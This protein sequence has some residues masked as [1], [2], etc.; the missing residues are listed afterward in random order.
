MKHLWLAFLVVLAASGCGNIT[1]ECP[2]NLTACDNICADMATD[3]LACGAC[4]NV[5]SD[6]EQCVA[7]KC[8]CAAG[9]KLCGGT[10]ID[11][12]TDE[13]NCGDCGVTCDAG[14]VCDA[15]VCGC[16][17]GQMVCGGV[18]TDVLTSSSHCGACDDPCDSG[19]SC[20]NGVCG[21]P[22]SQT[23]CPGE[24]ADLQT[25]NANCGQCDRVCGAGKACS[26]GNCACT[27]GTNILECNAVCI[28]KLTNNSHCG[29]CN[30]AC[31]GGKT[32]QAGSCQCTGGQVSCS[33][34]ICYDVTAD[35]N[36]CGG[37][38]SV[39]N[40][41]QLCNSGCSTAPTL[42]IATQWESPTGW[43][44]P[45]NVALTMTF[46]LSPTTTAQG[47]TYECRT[48]LVG[49]TVPNFA[50]C[51]GGTGTTA[52]YHPPMTG[53]GDGTHRTEVRYLQNGIPIGTTKTYD[54]YAHRKLNGVAKCPTV[55]TPI[56]DTAVFNLA[57]TAVVAGWSVPATPLFTGDA[58]LQINN[59]FIAIPFK[60]VR[61]SNS[62][63]S[64]L[65]TMP[66]D[67]VVKDLSLRHRWVLGN[68]N[69]LLLMKRNYVSSGGGCQNLSS[70]HHVGTFNFAQCEWY[71]LNINGV[72]LCIGRNANN[73]LPEIKGAS[74]IAGWWRMRTVR[75]PNWQTGAVGDRS[76]AYCAAAGCSTNPALIY[77]PP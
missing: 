8:E 31:N 60:Q 72:G 67:Y 53:L 39:C 42:N 45:G 49:G 21:C 59:P 62:M 56:T 26:G 69:R 54:F 41:N 27:G 1:R 52:I 17:V 34:N 13:A 5:C 66:R 44:L 74:Y 22:V 18:C 24:C 75:Y 33:D 3:E 46:S 20:T 61:P 9:G 64:D 14:E 30:M 65:G 70:S 4:G 76:S 73:T 68:S 47:I 11:V 25:D 28:D 6:M 50:K 36:H 32:C 35:R 38:C 55:A 12:A 57:A 37:G 15:G 71:V 19:V 58:L 40:V 23:Q 10:C 77:L 51:D 48:Y 7:G 43:S 63:G 16:P 29:M 2:S